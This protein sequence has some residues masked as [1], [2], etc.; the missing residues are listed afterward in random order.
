LRLADSHIRE[1]LG[2]F[3]RR[4]QRRR[5]WTPHTSLRPGRGPGAH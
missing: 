2:V 1:I 5:A 3:P 4:P